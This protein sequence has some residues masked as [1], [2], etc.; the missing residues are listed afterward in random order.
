MLDLIV[1]AG[2][3]EANAPLLRGALVLARRQH[4][5]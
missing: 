2:T 1:N 5:S 4:A 3:A